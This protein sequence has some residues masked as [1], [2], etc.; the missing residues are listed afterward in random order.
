VSPRAPRD[1]LRPSAGRAR[2]SVVRSDAAPERH[3]PLRFQEMWASIET[4]TLRCIAEST[5]A[6]GH[7]IAV[8]S[9]PRP[10]ERPAPS[11]SGMRA[12]L[13]RSRTH[14]L[15]DVFELRGAA[16]V[17]WLSRTHR[18]S[19]VS[20]TCRRARRWSPVRARSGDDTRFTPHTSRAWSRHVRLSS[21]SRLSAL[22]RPSSRERCL[23]PLFC[24]HSV[25][26][27]HPRER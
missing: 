26:N 18:A 4:G 23:L 5:G 21:Y 13:G 22:A 12:A 1:P 24:S 19:R 3:L 7:P 15:I 6:R 10:R 9:G 27:E 14:H 16:T 25:F 17:A 11:L 8:S 20:T 2:S